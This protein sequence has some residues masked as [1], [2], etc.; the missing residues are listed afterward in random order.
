MSTTSTRRSRRTPAAACGAAAVAVAFAVVVPPATA[1]AAS[2]VLE[3]SHF[4]ITYVHVEQ[5]IGECLDVAFPI[6]HDGASN[7]QVQQRTR[8]TDGPVY[9]SLRYNTSDVYT[10]VD[11]GAF[12]TA[13]EVVRDADSRVVENADGTLSISYAS[14]RTITVHT[15]SGRLVGVDSGRVTGTVVLDPMDPADPE[16]DVVLFEE[17]S[18]PTGVSRLGGFDLCATAV[19]LLG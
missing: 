1:Q 12:F 14:V 8:G 7:V 18:E 19:T 4:R 5:E 17:V 3:N 2:P 9:F 6:R 16:D 11:T 15:S 13:R 10:N